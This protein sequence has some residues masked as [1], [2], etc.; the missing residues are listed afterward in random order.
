MKHAFVL[1][2]DV[3]EIAPKDNATRRIVFVGE[4]VARGFFFDRSYSCS[5]VLNTILNSSGNGNTF[6]VVDLSQS[7]IRMDALI[8]VYQSSF[9]LNP[10][11]IVVF[12]GNNWTDPGS[13]LVDSDYREISSAKDPV[14]QFRITR[15]ILEE[16]LN[17]AVK[18]AMDV[19]N[20]CSRIHKVPVIFIIPE[21]NAHGWQLLNG[22]DTIVLWPDTNI[23]EIN[24]LLKEGADSLCHSNLSQLNAIA[25]K[26]IELTPSHPTAYFWKYLYYRY[27]E[28]PDVAWQYATMGR[29]VGIVRAH[30][31]PGIF[32]VTKES[33]LNYP[34]GNNVTILTL[35]G[36]LGI[37]VSDPSSAEMFMDYCHLSFEGIVR[38]MTT[39]GSVIM[40]CFKIRNGPSGNLF[41]DADRT[42]LAKA[43]FCAAVHNAHYGPQLHALGYY[44]RKAVE[45]DSTAMFWMRNYI[46]FTLS[47]LP[48]DL[49]PSF[50]DFVR[51]NVSRTYEGFMSRK[52]I[53]DEA[54]IQRMLTIVNGDINETF[55]DNTHLKLHHY[56][57]PG[58]SFDLLET[59]YC[60]R[61]YPTDT[62]EDVYFYS[63]LSI[64]S[65]FWFYI[66]L[67]ECP[68]VDI[69]IT[70]RV[71]AA[72]SNAEIFVNRKSI[73]QIAPSKKWTNVH[74]SLA[75]ENLQ[76]GKNLVTIRWPGH[77]EDINKPDSSPRH[78]VLSR[79]TRAFG[80]IHSF[81]A[82]AVLP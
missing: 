10:D 51:S 13:T 74:L 78:R 71:P 55:A 62:R 82:V 35:P 9:A 36:I 22:Q 30:F 53:L 31:M 23:N 32:S 27:Q 15:S 64:E 72:R 18:H 25:D 79:Y 24:S 81:K 42:E 49:N 65:E 16:K 4:S 37:D 21:F 3:D 19:I 68:Q 17:I 33:I 29:D 5:K 46:D 6:E 8:D 38:A 60:S 69:E 41:A 76:G 11:F 56:L 45:Y 7:S 70:Y 63:T 73:V 57:R 1:C 58:R 20:E 44:C 61:A 34:H 52:N 54:L 12:A 2:A 40:D 66:D 67:D 43:H 80:E 59:F 28:Q 75:Q 39:I 77:L 14:D 50:L 47:K 48:W 26:L